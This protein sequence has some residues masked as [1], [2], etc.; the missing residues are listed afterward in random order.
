MARPA[1]PFDKE[2]FFRALADRTRL[3]LINLM[4]DDEVCVCFFVEVIGTNQPKI[5]R[6]LAY[7]RR[8]G[9]VAA[10]RQGT[11]MH[12]RI[13]APHDEGAARVLEDVRAWL[14][15]D[16]EMR[17]D[18]ARLVDVCCAPDPPPHLEGAPRPASIVSCGCP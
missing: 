4:G 15:N 1:K 7:L 10:R 16:A 6:H 18:R 5:S 9:I 13:V 8:A 3:R 11:W 17:A 2:P 14:A 12:Y